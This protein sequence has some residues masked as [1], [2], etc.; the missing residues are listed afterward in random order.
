VGLAKSE[1]QLKGAGKARRMLNGITDTEM[2][3]KNPWS[4]EPSLM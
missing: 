1:A 4:P 2:R 3:K